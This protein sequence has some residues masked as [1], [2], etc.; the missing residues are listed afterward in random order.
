[1]ILKT[2]GLIYFLLENHVSVI[3]RKPVLEERRAI[4]I[5]TVK[6]RLIFLTAHGILARKDLYVRGL[7]KLSILDTL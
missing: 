6:M 1:M 2:I 4:F 3:Y 5:K 7:T